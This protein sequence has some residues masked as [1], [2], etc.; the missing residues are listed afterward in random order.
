MPLRGSVRAEIIAELKNIFN[1]QQTSAVGT[2]FLTDA[3]GNPTFPI[4]SD[5]NNFSVAANNFA[6][7]SGYEQRKFQ[8][9]FRLRF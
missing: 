1:K 4:P 7:P 9:G 8:L 5:T 3:G 2:T 6:V